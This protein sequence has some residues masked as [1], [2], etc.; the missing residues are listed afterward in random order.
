MKMYPCYIITENLFDLFPIIMWEVEL[1]SEF[2]YF[3]EGISKQT[4]EGSEWFLLDAYNK[5]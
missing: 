2:G 5:M 3:A 4:V 1:I